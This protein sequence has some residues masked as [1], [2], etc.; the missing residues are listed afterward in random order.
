[1]P[2]PPRP[3]LLKVWQ[4]EVT[5][6]SGPPGEILQADKTGVTVACGQGSLLISIL[7][8][9]G[10]KRLTAPEFLSGHS[11]PAGQKLG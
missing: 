8:L 3:H 7:Q 11:L 2:G 4:A 6:R 10:G 1:L 9:E 5:E